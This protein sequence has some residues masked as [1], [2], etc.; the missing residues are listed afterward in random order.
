[1]G[2]SLDLHASSGQAALRAAGLWDAYQRL[3]RYDA[4]AYT[5]SDRA[6]ARHIS[7][8]DLDLGR[9]EIDRPQLRRL[10]L[11]SLRAGTVRW[12]CKL[13]RVEADGT[14]RFE[15]AGAEVVEEG[16]GLV[17]GADGAWS[18]VRELLCTVPPVYAGIA[19]YELWIVD[20]DRTCPEVS[21]AAGD[22]THFAFGD[23]ERSLNT[24]RQS[25]RS[26]QVLVYMRKPERWLN[27]NGVKDHG[28]REQVRE[29]LLKEFD[30]WAPQF[31]EVLEAVDG[32]VFPR[33]L[34][35]M[36]V[37]TRW[38]HKK[39]F[40]LIGD[41]AHLMTPFT[42]EGVNQAMQ[43]AMLLAKEIVKRGLGDADAAAAAYERDMFPR[44]R[45]FMQATWESQQERYEPDGNEKWAEGFRRV[46]ED[47]QS[48]TSVKDG[49]KPD[50]LFSKY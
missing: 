9:P 38:L 40:T 15:R 32:K 6:G 12:G 44:A 42:G 36:H 11:E 46:V 30:G 45:E 35:M 41:A 22:G 25:D 29:L 19:G 14:L 2:G 3:A 37:G 43:D 50:R 20:P 1:M 33:N 49:S 48:G 24:Q 28:D 5:I 17:V 18:K 47:I 4:Q 16:F 21:K 7:I 26:L 39:G 34:Y 8:R 13:R 10:L 31:K 23:D 27:E